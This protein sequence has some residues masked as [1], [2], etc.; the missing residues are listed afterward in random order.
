MT[1]KITE[2]R[3]GHVAR[4][5]IDNTAKRNAISQ[6]MW[7]ELADR[8]EVL[9]A[10]EQLRCIVVRGAGALA[11]GSGADIEEFEQLRS[12][13]EKGIAFGKQAH[14]A[15]QLLKSCPVPTLAA[16][17]GACIGGGLELAACCDIR[18]ASNDAKFGI[19]IGRLGGV[20]AYPE[21][22]ALLAIATPS[23]AYELL[24]EGRVLNAEQAYVKGLIARSVPGEEFEAEIARSVKNIAELAPLSARWHK[25]FIARLGS[26]QPLDEAQRN[27]A[28][29][30]FDTEDFQEGFKAFLEKRKPVFK[31]Q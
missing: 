21:L 23:V 26:R 11:F 18:I 12:S 29:D 14:R 5:L 31:G 28:Y 27:Q 1:G 13:K 20:L 9:N 17:Q 22:E 15:M 25:Q 4:L 19:P 30:C 6:A 2:E 10:D 8:L 24:F 16:I 3:D 7:V